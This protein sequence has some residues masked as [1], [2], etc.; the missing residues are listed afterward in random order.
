MGHIIWE[1]KKYQRSITKRNDTEWIFTVVLNKKKKWISYQLLQF[2]SSGVVT[3]YC[4]IHEAFWL[5]EHHRSHSFR[6]AWSSRIVWFFL[7]SRYTQPVIDNY[8]Y[9]RTIRCNYESKCRRI[10]KKRRHGRNVWVNLRK[11]KSR[12]WPDL[13]PGCWLVSFSMWINRN[14]GDIAVHIFFHPV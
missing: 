11:K 5:W 6:I 13:L 4:E 10:N 14:H 12:L 8:K 9:R 7:E 3:A 1:T 2:Y